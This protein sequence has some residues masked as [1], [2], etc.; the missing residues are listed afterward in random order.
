MQTI[1]CDLPEDEGGPPHFEIDGETGS[2]RTTELF[3]R[4][5]RPFYTLRICAR[6]GGA[7]PLESL[8]VVHVQ[9]F[10]FPSSVS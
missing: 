2:I 5:T 8:A 1:L 10:P 6:D 9:V 3:T 4:N 7:P